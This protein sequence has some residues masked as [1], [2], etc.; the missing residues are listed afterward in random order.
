MADK[1]RVQL[2]HTYAS[3]LFPILGAHLSFPDAGLVPG[4]GL[5]VIT[6]SLSS[7]NVRLLIIQLIKGQNM[8][9]R[10]SLFLLCHLLTHM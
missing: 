4:T 10:P 6:G 3:G 7:G 5:V 8:K 1:W 9:C 2:S